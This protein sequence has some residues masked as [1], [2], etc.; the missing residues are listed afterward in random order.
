MEHV[1][2][3]LIRHG[4]TDYNKNGIVQGGGVDSSLNTTGIQ[5]AQAFFHHYQKETFHALYCSPLQ[6]TAQTLSPWLQKGYQL[7]SVEQLIE[8]S[9]GVHEGLVP[10]PKQKAE[11]LAVKQKWTEGE[12]DLSVDGGETPIQVWE[13][14]KK[15]LAYLFDK[16]AGERVLVC[17]HGRLL[18][19]LLSGLLDQDISNMEAYTQPNTGLHLVELYAPT[20]GHAIKL[21]DTEHLINSI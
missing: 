17:S 18:R 11:F 10:S 6:R 3:Y 16:H 5:Q 21:A 2:L 12:L 19:I 4:E 9:W 7:Q 1:L 14:S 8:I 15:A 20:R 13:R